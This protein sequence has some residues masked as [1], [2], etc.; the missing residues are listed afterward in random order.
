LVQ[1]ARLVQELELQLLAGQLLLV[2]VLPLAR[3]VRLELLA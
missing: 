1:L 2:P 3:L